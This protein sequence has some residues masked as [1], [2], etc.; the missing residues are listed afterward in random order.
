MTAMRSMPNY[1]FDADLEMKD[2]YLVAADAAATVD[3]VAKIADVGDAIFSGV[4][5][6]DV[7]AIETDSSN[8][9]YRICV[10]GSNSSTFASGIENLAEKTLG[11]S[12]GAGMAG[13]QTSVVGRYLLPF[14]NTQRLTSTTLDTYRYI[15]VYTDV[16][17][18]LATGINYT[19]RVGKTR[20]A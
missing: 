7:S 9:V 13:A 17:G 10:Q 20:A 11:H 8:E 19:A 5:V 15:R 4:L 18:T 1:T 16:T 2:A 14:V 6:I 12:S 3:S